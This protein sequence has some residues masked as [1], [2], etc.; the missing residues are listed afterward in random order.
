MNLRKLII[1]NHLYYGRDGGDNFVEQTGTVAVANGSAT[2]T[3]TGTTFT[4][5]APGTILAIGPYRVVVGS[6]TDATH[7]TMTA[8][9]GGT[10][11]SLLLWWKQTANSIDYN[12]KP[13]GAAWISVGD[14][15]DLN[16]A[17][18]RT[19]EQVYSPS[20]G[21]YRLSEIFSKT[22]ELKLDFTLQDMSEFFL[23]LL[24]TSVGPVVTD[25]I[26]YSDDGTIHGWFRVTQFSQSD[27]QNSIMEVWGR[28]TADATKFGNEHAKGKLSLRC[29]V[30][31]LNSGIA[32]LA[33]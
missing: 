22:T 8:A 18:T 17:P 11:Q 13:V 25:F 6:V 3:G 28:A 26:P 15:E 33:A 4:G 5:I 9:W 30:N 20:P 31:P 16:F 1:G 14:I 23:E 10:T 32:T 7:L 19:E 2:L 21:N 24:T 29:L 27:A 12:T